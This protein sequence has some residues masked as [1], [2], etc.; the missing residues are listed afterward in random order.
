MLRSIDGLQSDFLS[1]AQIEASHEFM[2]LDTQLIEDGTYFLCTINGE[3]AGCGGWSYRATLFGGT[4]SVGRDAARLDPAADPARVRAM[5]TDPDFTRRGVGR[6]IINKCESAAA[7]AGFKRTR[8]AATLSGE[9]LYRTVGYEPV[10]NC[11]AK[12]SKGVEVPLIEM[13]KIL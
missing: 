6:A 2:G 13:E 12:S 7:A 5:Y 10:R 9:P 11:V 3:H 4:H 1:A 8:L